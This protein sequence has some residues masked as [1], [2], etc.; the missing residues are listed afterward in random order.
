[1]L[2]EVL[3]VGAVGLLVTLV[4]VLRWV[5]SVNR[6]FRRLKGWQETAERCG[7]TVVK[8]SNLVLVSLTARSGPVEIE[9]N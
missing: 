9:L 2:L 8:T 1:M 7:L 3:A 5:H 4:P 6:G